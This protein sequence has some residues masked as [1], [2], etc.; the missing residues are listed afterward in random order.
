MKALER[1]IK[2][3]KQ[4][5]SES[6]NPGLTTRYGSIKCLLLIKNEKKKLKSSGT[7][8]TG[9]DAEFKSQ[10]VSNSSLGSKVPASRRISTSRTCANNSAGLQILLSINILQLSPGH[11]PG[12]NGLQADFWHLLDM[13]L[14]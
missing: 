9:N 5:T 2:L 13:E 6:D 1:D 12:I 10:Q 4:E 8:Q 3:L 7:V 11:S 14:L